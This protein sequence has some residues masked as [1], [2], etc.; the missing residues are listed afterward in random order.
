MNKIIGKSVTIIFIIIISMGLLC[1]LKNIIVGIE[2][3]W[4]NIKN[5][6]ISTAIDSFESQFNENLYN[7]MDMVDVNGAFEY[8]LGKKIINGVAIDD[9]YN[10]HLLSYSEEKFSKKKAEKSLKYT[11]KILDYSKQHG[12]E[13][14]YVEHPEKFDNKKS[15]LP[16]K[17]NQAYWK[18]DE[19]NIKELKKDN[20]PIL[21]LRDDKYKANKF[22]KTDHHWTIE[23][24]F[25]ATSAIL[26]Y[27]DGKMQL[28][29]ID[30]TTNIDNYNVQNYPN[31]YLGSS[32]VRTGKFVVGKDD[33][34]KVEPK[35]NT[36]IIY[37][38]YDEL[39]N[40]SWELNGKYK[41]TLIKQSIFNDIN[42]NN[43]YSAYLY[44][45]YIE[46]R[47]YNKLA[48]NKEKVLF[49][50][51]SFSR[52]VVSFLSLNFREVRSLDPQEGRYNNSYLNYIKEYQPDI[53]IVMYSYNYSDKTLTV[54]KMK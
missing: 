30:K 7:K 14:L 40:K 50:S 54:D 46:A 24:A 13:I 16:Y 23:S 45:G 31:S 43:K 35:F 18:M 19:Y 38:R 36:Q 49:I 25:N 27:L 12:A 2:S 34:I 6:N 32:G 42:Y 26:K 20:Y 47:L 48:Q 10:L 8:L 29:N 5:L 11:K 9:K 37:E 51:D 28:K 3:N 22:F 17:L 41:D 44:D 52:P 15:I 4:L 39:G 53:V 1:N 21:D 33:I